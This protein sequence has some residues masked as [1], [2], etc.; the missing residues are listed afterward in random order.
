MPPTSRRMLLASAVAVGPVATSIACSAPTASP[1]SGP[2]HNYIVLLRD[3][4]KD[5]AVS[6]G[7]GS[8]RVLAVQRDQAPL[9]ASARQMGA[10]NVHGFTLVNGFAASLTDAQLH[11]FVANPQVAAV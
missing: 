3:Q 1:A 8:P 2:T 5:L 9:L 11:S 7:M 10:R 4:H 6:K